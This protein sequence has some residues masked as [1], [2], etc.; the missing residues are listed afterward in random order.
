MI[1]SRKDYEELDN[2][3]WKLKRENIIIKQDDR[4]LRGLNIDCGK[5]ITELE[6][7][8]ENTKKNLKRMG[9]L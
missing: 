9:K 7:E 6:E 3:R 4:F 8:L 1:I 2:E 5:R